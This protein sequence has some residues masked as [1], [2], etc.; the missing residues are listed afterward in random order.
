MSNGVRIKRYKVT[1]AGTRGLKV[2]LPQV[3]VDDVGITKNDSI[4]VYRDTENRLIIVKVGV[5]IPQV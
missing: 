1:R 3:W 4:D 5:E 2:N